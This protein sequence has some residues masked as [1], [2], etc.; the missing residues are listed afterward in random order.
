MGCD[1]MGVIEL[2]AE[3]LIDK[4]DVTIFGMGCN[5]TVELNRELEKLPEGATREEVK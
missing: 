4:D 2:L 1:C 3:K 5:G